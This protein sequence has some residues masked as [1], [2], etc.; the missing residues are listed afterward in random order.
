MNNLKIK[1]IAFFI[2]KNDTVVDVGCDHAYLAIY[3]AKNNLCKKI[4][5]SDINENALNNAKTNIAK[6]KLS[7]KIKCV[8]S[9]GLNEVDVKNINTVAIAGMGFKTIKHI[10]S[11]KEKFANIDKLII[12]S[13]NDWLLLRKYMQKQGY[14]LDKEKI[15]YEKGHFYVICK[16]VKGKQRL[17][18]KELL[19]GLYSKANIDYYKYLLKENKKILKKIPFTKLRAR[20]KL[21]KQNKI[22]KKYINFK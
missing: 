5:A 16:Y 11:N 4:I 8:L 21:K 22:L 6:N 19:F 15:I 2:G 7:K 1:A 12:S 17:S 3:L 14:K 13:N 9:D 18:K 20:R 10:L